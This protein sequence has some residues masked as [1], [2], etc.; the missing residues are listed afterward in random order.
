[1]SIKIRPIVIYVAR[2]ILTRGNK[3]NMNKLDSTEARHL[4]RCAV[5]ALNTSNINA[6]VL[7]IPTW[8]LLNQ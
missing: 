2:A 7:T 5:V 1:M 3:E 4:E 8:V 6:N